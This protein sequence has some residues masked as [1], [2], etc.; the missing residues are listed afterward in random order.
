MAHWAFRINLILVL[1]LS[2]YRGPIY[3]GSNMTPGVLQGYSIYRAVVLNPMD[4]ALVHGRYLPNN[5]GTHLQVSTRRQIGANEI[6]SEPCLVW[7][8]TP[9]PHKGGRKRIERWL[10]MKGVALLVLAVVKKIML[11]VIRVRLIC[12]KRT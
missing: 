10:E 7:G 12:N 9:L 6:K 1:I 8:S 11:R 4:R 3:M 2:D 5:V